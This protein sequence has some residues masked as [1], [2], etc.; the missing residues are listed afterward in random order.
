MKH[1]N[2]PT[3]EQCSTGARVEDF[4]GSPAYACWYPQMGGYVG[5]AVVVITPC[6]T[7]AGDEIVDHCFEAFVWHDGDFP[8]DQSDEMGRGP[9]RHLHHCMP[10]QFIQFGEF[11]LKKQEECL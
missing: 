7:G 3:P 1:P 6:G 10:S 4:D 5:R 8:F 2:M 9:V 11:V